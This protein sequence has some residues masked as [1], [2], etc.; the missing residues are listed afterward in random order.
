MDDNTTHYGIRDSP[1]VNGVPASTPDY[2]A[3]E[4]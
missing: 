4:E 1:L 2:G 3:H